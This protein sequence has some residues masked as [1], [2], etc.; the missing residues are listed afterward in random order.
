[1]KR[2]PP[3]TAVPAI[4]SNENRSAHRG[5][6][7]AFRHQLDVLVRR[8]Y[9]R[10]IAQLVAHLGGSQLQLAEDVAQEA[11]VKAMAVWPYQ[12][13]P[14]HPRAWLARVARNR[15]IDRLRRENRE[16]S[17]E[18]ASEPRAVE[19]PDTLFASRISDPE[20]R[21]MLLCCHPVLSE[22]DR[23]ALTLRIVLGFTAAEIASVLLN[24]QAALAQRL[25][26]AQ[27][28]LKQQGAEV[29]AM[30]S[31]FE[32]R[33]RSD[34]LL[35]ITYLAFSLAY[36]PRS[37]AELVRQDIALEAVRLARELA[38]HELTRSP[39]A[40]ALAALL[41]FQA[42]RLEAR[43]NTDGTLILLRDQNRS[44]WNQPLIAAGFGHLQA[45]QAGS[46]LSRYH[47]EAGIASVHVAAAS[48]EE[49]DWAL[50]VKQYEQL[51]AVHNSPVV[52]INA[53]VAR[54]MAGQAAVALAQLEKLEGQPE[55]RDYAPYH[56]AR[57]EILS[58]LGQPGAAREC[59]KKALACSTSDPV[60]RHLQLQM[61]ALD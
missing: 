46:G 61:Q 25:A 36:A 23:L 32:I 54:A 39:Q 15:A 2:Q 57:A 28:K 34:T 53:C 22:T 9:G 52:T 1:M 33:R 29:D 20:L 18:E 43:Q 27:R 6:R 21:L 59:L 4:D 5:E 30:L 35:K 16:T 55:L 56:I 10:L 38:S 31:V 49:C 19:P 7:A 50:M 58:Q 45:S 40:N 51:Q 26:R 47:L 12:G 24:S 41:C 60:R 17:F 42:S 8:E 37:G 48:W 3:S 44:Q 11:L 14:D 13:M